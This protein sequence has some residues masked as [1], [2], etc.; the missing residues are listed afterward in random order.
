MNGVLIAGELQGQFE[1]FGVSNT[2]VA[3]DKHRARRFKDEGREVIGVL[4]RYRLGADGAG[5]F[6]EDDVIVWMSPPSSS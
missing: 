3:V 5:D 4:A 6:D 1:Q 2:S